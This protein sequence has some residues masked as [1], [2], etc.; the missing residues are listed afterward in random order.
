MGKRKCKTLISPLSIY[1]PHFSLYK[2]N[3]DGHLYLDVYFVINQE[4]KKKIIYYIDYPDIL[5]NAQ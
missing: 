2:E 1:F 4:L 5:Q 3:K